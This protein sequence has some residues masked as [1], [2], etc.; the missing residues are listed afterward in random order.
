MALKVLAILCSLILISKMESS[1]FSKLIMISINIPLITV[2]SYVILSDLI[3]GIQTK[4][5]E[6]VSWY[7]KQ[8]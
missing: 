4:S 5:I 6:R 7:P 1:F 2:Q 8:V 3:Y